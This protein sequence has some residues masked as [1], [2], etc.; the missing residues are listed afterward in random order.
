MICV[1]NLN[2]GAPTSRIVRI[3]SW[4]W[5]RIRPGLAF[6]C[7]S[8]HQEIVE[9]ATLRIRVSHLED[10][11]APTVTRDITI[12]TESPKNVT[13]ARAARILAKSCPEFRRRRGRTSSAAGVQI[14]PVLEKTADG[15]RAWR[16]CTSN[17]QPS[18]FE[19]PLKGRVGKLNSRNN[20]YSDRATGSWEQADISVVAQTDR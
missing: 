20:P 2:F 18:G 13:K 5:L 15:W 8:Q 17:G 12:E 7:R 4:S 14:L 6:D 19:P 16:L 11:Q 10:R 1:G 9:M 3:R